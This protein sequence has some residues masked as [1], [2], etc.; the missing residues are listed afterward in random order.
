MPVSRCL[1]KPDSARTL[2]WIIYRVDVGHDGAKNDSINWAASGRLA[3]DDLHFICAWRIMVR[4][5]DPWAANGYRPKP[6][7]VDQHQETNVVISKNCSVI[8]GSG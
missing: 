1:A 6:F 5:V 3:L 8:I 4:F 2:L 7:A